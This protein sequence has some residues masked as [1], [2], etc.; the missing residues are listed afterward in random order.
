MR[1]KVLRDSVSMK[2]SYLAHIRPF[3]LCVHTQQKE[4]GGTREF[5][6]VS[7]MRALILFMRI[8]LL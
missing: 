1:I 8:L 2:T 4:G 3:Y 5:S 7:F 6:R